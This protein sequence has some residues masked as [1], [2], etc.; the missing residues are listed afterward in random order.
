MHGLAEEIWLKILVCQHFLYCTSSKNKDDSTTSSLKQSSQPLCNFDTLKLPVNTRLAV[1][2]SCLLVSNQNLQ[3][4][5]QILT[6]ILWRT[7]WLFSTLRINENPK[8]FL[9]A[10]SQRLYILILY[11]L[12]QNSTKIFLRFRRQKISKTLLEK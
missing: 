11:Q 9:I 10:I 8:P 5:Q 7:N 1:S 3:R 2:G 4:T 12:H 6:I